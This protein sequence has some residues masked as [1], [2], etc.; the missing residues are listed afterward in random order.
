MPAIQDLPLL[1][2]LPLDK[3]VLHEFHDPQRTPPI[4][5]SIRESGIL[6]S[7]PIVVPFQDGTQR[8]MVLDG[9]NRVTAIQSLDIPHIV[10]QVV[11]TDDEGL[12]LTP[13]KHVVWGVSPETLLEWVAETPNMSAER[14]GWWEKSS[15]DAFTDIH[16]LAFLHLA[17]G[18]SYRLATSHHQLLP[19]MDTLNAFV[20]RYA[21]EARMDRTQFTDMDTLKKL[22]TELTG[23]VI[24]PPFRVDQIL[25]IVGKG[26]L[27][28]PGST[29][30][31]ISPRVLHLNYPLSELEKDKSLEEKNTILGNLLKDRL[32]QKS[33]RYYAESTFLFDE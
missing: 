8:Y 11:N 17:D 14:V 3:F 31:S 29:R 21:K 22:Y 26:R 30:F 7:P 19:R 15:N 16:V 20:N 9:A 27:M 6:R 28:P 18:T 23:L 25:H 33:V 32:A 2:I 4:A 10:A 1:A 12:S 13:W 5:K 24:L